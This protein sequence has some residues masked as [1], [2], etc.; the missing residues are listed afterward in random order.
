MH[1]NTYVCTY[2]CMYFLI[3]VIH[4]IHATFLINAHCISNYPQMAYYGSVSCVVQ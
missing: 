2:V 1:F 3:N 4:E